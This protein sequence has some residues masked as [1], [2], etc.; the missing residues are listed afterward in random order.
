M[1]YGRMGADHARQVDSFPPFLLHGIHITGARNT[2]FITISD[3]CIA[4]LIAC[5]HHAVSSKS[6]V[7]RWCVRVKK[8][9]FKGTTLYAY[10]RHSQW[11]EAQTARRTATTGLGLLRGSRGERGRGGNRSL[12]MGTCTGRGWVCQR[13]D[14]LLACVTETN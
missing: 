9:G 8:V 6:K 12:K 10:M 14:I 13:S 5:R 4:F 1:L 2:S 7:V 11:R 3:A